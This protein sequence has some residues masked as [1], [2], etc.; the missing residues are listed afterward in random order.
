LKYDGE[1]TALGLASPS[2]QVLY[3]NSIIKNDNQT[4]WNFKTFTMILK[5]LKIINQDGI[6]IVHLPIVLS[7]LKA[8]E[9]LE[10]IR[11]KIKVLDSKSKK[12]LINQSIKSLGKSVVSVGK[13][14][15]LEEDAE[16]S[17]GALI[18]MKRLLFHKIEKVRT[19][20]AYF[21]NSHLLPL[22]IDKICNGID[23]LIS[24]Q[25]N[26][27]KHDDFKPNTTDLFT[28]VDR[29][30]SGIKSSMLS[31]HEKVAN[32]HTIHDND[33]NFN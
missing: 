14:N 28:L 5:N 33:I 12:D 30:V 20:V 27:N 11:A 31:P 24:L 21:K 4:L 23:K 16:E 22:K 26:D 19:A 17:N 15:I 13:P 7:L 8:N 9:E 10:I 29:K 2:I 25:T 1:T 6:V 3:A 32:D 18:I